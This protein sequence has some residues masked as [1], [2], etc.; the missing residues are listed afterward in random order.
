MA[1]RAESET[2]AT[3]GTDPRRK[4]KPYVTP[5]LK[6]LGSVRDLTLGS[7]VGCAKEGSVKFPRKRGMAM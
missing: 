2:M 5:T 4:R 7:T 1:E 6:R 3:A